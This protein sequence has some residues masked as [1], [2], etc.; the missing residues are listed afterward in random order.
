MD[1]ESPFDLDNKSMVDF[2]QCLSRFHDGN[3]LEAY[4]SE[5]KSTASKV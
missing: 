2:L 5:R 1:N 4:T 3:E